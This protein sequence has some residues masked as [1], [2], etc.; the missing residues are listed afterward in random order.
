MEELIPLILAIIWLVYS[1]YKKNAKKKQK[2]PALP[3]EE[4]TTT[5][6]SNAKSI[7]ERILFGEEP[8]P[9]YNPQSVEIPENDFVNYDDEAI[10][11]E[12][13]KIKEEIIHD[14][15]IWQKTDAQFNKD[16][17]VQDDKSAK[18]Q[19]EEFD[20]RKAVIHSI[21]LERPYK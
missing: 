16:Y 9:A 17:Q 11:S 6:P 5:K 19:G 15:V 13:T 14:P 7:L 21:V 12:E 4:T 1:L 2:S 10:A 20:L 8:S 3:L 18:I